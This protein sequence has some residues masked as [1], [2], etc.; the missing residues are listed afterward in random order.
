MVNAR[1]NDLKTDLLHAGLRKEIEL[2]VSCNRVNR[3]LVV[4]LSG[5]PD[6]LAVLE[7]DDPKRVTLEHHAVRSACRAFF[8]SDAR[9]VQAFFDLEPAVRAFVLNDLKIRVDSSIHFL[10]GFV[11]KRKIL[12]PHREV[13]RISGVAITFRKSL[14]LAPVS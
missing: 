4:M 13:A 2:V 10:T 9:N 8:A 5:Y 1:L 6:A 7:V 3:K 11:A 12:V 14:R